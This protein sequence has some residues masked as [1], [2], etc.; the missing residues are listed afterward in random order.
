MAVTSRSWPP[1]GSARGARSEGSREA[2]RLR[3]DDPAFAKELATITEA[4]VVALVHGMVVGEPLDGRQRDVLEGL[5]REELPQ[6]RLRAHL[7]TRA[8][9]EEDAD[10]DEA[11]R[12]SREGERRVDRCVPS[13]HGIVPPVIGPIGRVLSD[14]AKRATSAIRA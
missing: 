3:R 2:V 4:T 13:P 5:L 10:Q 1:A 12:D 8:P 14:T 6:A 7:V 9:G 11:R